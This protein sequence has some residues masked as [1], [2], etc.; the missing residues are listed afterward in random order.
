MIKG[1]EPYEGLN[2]TYNITEDCNL[3]CT[4]CYEVDKQPRDL[5]LEYAKRFNTILLTDPDPIGS[6]ETE[7]DWLIRKGVILDF[8]GGDALM[9]PKLVAAIIR[10]FMYQA[11]LMEH[12]WA[13]RWRASIST[14]GTLFSAPGVKEFLNEFRHN[15]SVGVSVDG[16]PEVHNLNR[17]DSMDAILKDWAWYMNF[18]GP[19][20]STKAT[21][22]RQSIPYLYQSLRFLHETL[23]LHHIN[24]NFIFE[25]MGETQEDLRTLDRQMAR[26]VE[27]VLQHK[28]DLHW[29]MLD[30]HFNEASCMRDPE[31]GWCGA[32]AMPT[33]GVN[34]KIYPC[35]RFMP[36][37]MHS[38]E[39][40]LA[41]GDVWNGFDHKENFKLVRDQ[42]RSKISEAKCLACDIETSC[43]WCIGGA[44]SE[45]GRFY[46]QTNICE[47]IKVQTKWAKEYWR[48][49]GGNR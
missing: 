5:P 42:T 38:R 41:V 15:L 25:P 13:R 18:A 22:N 9:R 23:G 17:S 1:L 36:H 24:M 39:L 33:L 46:R 10:D 30:T 48:L 43:S 31:K 4:Y 6:A 26:C 19:N 35:F 28:D 7:V 32:G 37:T 27:Y 14:N 20:A 29:S 16:C 21:L 34:G 45:A 12:R 3:R 11:S 44:Y 2:V 8:I 49:Y 47:V 40:D